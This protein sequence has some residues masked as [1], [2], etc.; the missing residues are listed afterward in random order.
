ME[1]PTEFPPGFAE[2]NKGP[3][4]IIITSAMTAL[5]SIFVIGRIYSRMISIGKLGVDD[6]IVIGSIVGS[7]VSQL[8]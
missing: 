5:A 3:E 1:S 2:E 7:P 6:Y 4:I 8:P